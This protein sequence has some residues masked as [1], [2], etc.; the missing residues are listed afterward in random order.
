MYAEERVGEEQRE[1]R[2]VL[3][4]GETDPAA[5]TGEEVLAE[6]EELEYLL[7]VLMRRLFTLDPDHPA[8]EL[9]LAQL[10]VCMILQPGA[11]P[12]SVI[13]DELRVSL[14]ALTQIADRLE[15]MGYVERICEADDRRVKHLQLTV[16]GMEMMRSRR[17]SRVGRAAEALAR[18]RPEA[19]QEGLRVIRALIDAC[20][21]S[22]PEESAAALR[23]DD[24][25][26]L[27]SDHGNPKREP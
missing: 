24:A 16:N 18:L 20:L 12:M 21:S 7:P 8:T 26:L 17:K 22:V 23:S 19:R 14:S 6:A 10:R 9:S 4:T 13:S 15:R 27:A 1:P 25:K 3:G 5:H 11:R 2:D